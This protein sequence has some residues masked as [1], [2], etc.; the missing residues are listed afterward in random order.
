M[1]AFRPLPVARWVVG[2]ALLLAAPAGPAFGQDPDTVPVAAPAPPSTGGWAGWAAVAH[3]WSTVVA[4]TVVLPT[5]SARDPEGLGGTAWLLGRTSA[6]AVRRR[7]GEGSVRVEADV[8]RSRTVYQVLTVPGAW[9]RAYRTLEDVLFDT[10]RTRPALD[11]ARASLLSTHAFEAG[12]PVREFE[13]ELYRML[14]GA[15]TP[16]SRDP[17]GAPES[18]ERIT[19]DDLTDY[20]R[21]NYDR[22]N[23]VLSVTGAVDTGEAARL[24]TGDG[25]AEDSLG[26]RHVAVRA[27]PATPSGP[28]WSDGDR[29]HRVRDVTSGWIAAAYPVDPATP[30]TA[31]EMV[32]HRVRAELVT[33]PP[34]PGLFSADVSLE[35]LPGGGTALLV[36]TAV[37]PESVEAWEGR[38]VRTLVRIAEEPLGPGFFRFHRRRFRNQRL[39]ADAGPEQEGLR[40]AL[41]LQRIGRPRDLSEEIWEMDGETLHEAAR[42][43]GPARVLV[44]GPDLATGGD[45]PD[46]AA[47]GELDAPPPGW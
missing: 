36:R 41:D 47:R 24:V 3:P 38:I 5:G 30:R 14:G 44:F 31:I 11:A 16:W 39:V 33:D 20:R 43:L 7:L 45:R 19:A 13:L 12:A 37:L 46:G 28:A 21:R 29:L 18:L 22:G 27:D 10:P 17:R 2:A 42:A 23:A 6:D 4:I 9:A 35:G 1:S 32:A 26:E 25:P 34:S 40:T 8:D 15:G